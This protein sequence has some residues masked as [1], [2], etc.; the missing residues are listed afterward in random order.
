[1]KRII[2]FF[3]VAAVVLI[4]GLSQKANPFAG[5]WDLTVTA[6]GHPF[7]SWLEVMEKDGQLE[8]R[9]QQRT[10]NVAPVA[11]VKMEGG[12][13][14]VSV[15]AAATARPA[16]DN[17]PATPARPELIWELTEKGG[18]LTGVH[19]QGDTTWQLAGVRAPSLDRPAPKSWG[20]PEPLFNGK[21]L[22]GW[23]PINN[24]PEAI[25]EKFTSHWAAKN[26][27]LTNEAR[28]SNI[29][30]KRTFQD[31]KL[32]VEWTCPPAEN[33][34]V[35][36][37]GRYETQVAPPPA[38]V[39]A[40]AQT[41]AKKG[42]TGRGGY[43]NPYGGVACIY[44]ML[45]PSK[46]PKFNAEWQVYDVTLVGRKVTVVFNGETLID[47]QEIAG[48]TGGALDSNEGEPGPIYFQGD[49]HSGI[50]YR[51]ITIALPKK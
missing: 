27:E 19:K 24:T 33:S 12:K 3:A 20:E 28:G 29:R 13:L 15:I 5:R 48:V 36:L 26:G 51:N 2:L 16:Q 46:P 38:P 1:M 7:P 42:G 25:A 18:K 4:P 49:H 11:G 50:R 32:H 23:E 35:Y 45:G 17:R 31:F 39:P 37:R 40:A 41:P 44:G 43:S 10:G 8:A 21:D 30:T 9:A 14:L 22:T 6:D 47:N 34:G